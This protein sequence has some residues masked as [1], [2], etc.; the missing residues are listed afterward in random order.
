MWLQLDESSMPHMREGAC[1][2]WGPVVPGQ[3]QRGHDAWQTHHARHE[4]KTRYHGT[5]ILPYHTHH[6]E[7]NSEGKDR[8]KDK[9]YIEKRT[10]LCQTRG[11]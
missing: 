10:E 7:Q 2:W 8:G 6:V 11:G 9:V 1:T 3:T 5:L 4:A